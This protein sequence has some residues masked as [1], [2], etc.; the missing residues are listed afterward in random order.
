M[1]SDKVLFYSLLALLVSTAVIG[2]L[3]STPARAQEATPPADSGC[4][5]CHEN[6]YYLHDTGNSFCLCAEQMSCTCCHGGNPQALKEDEAHAGMVLYPASDNASTCQKC[7]PADYQS[8]VEKFASVAGISAIHP[9]SPTSTAVAQ[10]AMNPVE[11]PPTW[12]L[13][14]RLLE[15]WRLAGLGMLTVALVLIVL[16]GY[17]CWKADCLLR[18]Q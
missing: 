16:F 15:P 9:P 4:I 7:H 1:P 17:R 13:S 8:R 2:G 5:T 11:N 14:M 6:L 18:S 10:I 3:S 12:A